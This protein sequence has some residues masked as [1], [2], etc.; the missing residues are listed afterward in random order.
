MDAI[1]RQAVGEELVEPLTL[2]ALEMK[3][4]R[5]VSL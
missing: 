5:V 2:I 4:W 3:S 1:Y